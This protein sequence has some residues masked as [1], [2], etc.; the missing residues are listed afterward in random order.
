M[1]RGFKTETEELIAAFRS[2]HGDLYDYSKVQFERV[3]DKVCIG[4]P[5]H[6]D[7]YQAAIY[8]RRGQKCPKCVREIPVSEETK[9]KMSATR[10]RMI[11][12]GLLVEQIQRFA[13]SRLGVPVSAETRAKM[14]AVRKGRAWSPE[15]RAKAE[16]GKR[17]HYAIKRMKKNTI[18][19]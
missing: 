19:E 3:K 2:A 17:L 12:E 4:C 11:A 18:D 10:K 1:P 6:G 5:K 8:H 15:H 14:S 13:K 16:L 9:A 7:F